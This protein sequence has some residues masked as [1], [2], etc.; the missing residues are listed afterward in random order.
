VAWRDSYGMLDI[1]IR[2]IV[3]GYRLVVFVE[4]RAEAFEHDPLMLVG[5]CLGHGRSAF[6]LDLIWRIP[7]LAK[8]RF[9]PG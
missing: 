1:T 2:P 9:G 3:F 4:V 8:E 5:R 6:G 7:Q